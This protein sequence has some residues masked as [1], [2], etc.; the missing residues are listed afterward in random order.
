MD[1]IV[2]VICLTLK[3]KFQYQISGIYFELRMKDLINESSSQLFDQLKQL[4]KEHLKKEKSGLKSI[5]SQ[6]K[7]MFSAIPVTTF[8]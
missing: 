7:S 8:M 3:V 4:R 1:I 6:I 5:R 2:P